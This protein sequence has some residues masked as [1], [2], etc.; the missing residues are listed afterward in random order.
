MQFPAIPDWGLLLVVVGGPSQILAEGHVCGSPPLLPGVRWFWWWVVP[1]Q[2]WLRALG[3]VPR[4]SWLRSAA[5][6][7]G[8]SL[9]IPG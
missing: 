4:H 3:A 7:G 8:W 1:C 2:S 6:G 5:G 9:C